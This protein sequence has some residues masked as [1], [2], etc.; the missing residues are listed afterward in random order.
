M[1]KVSGLAGMAASADETYRP[2][3]FELADRARSSSVTVTGVVAK[4]APR[5]GPK[6]CIPVLCCFCVQD[7]PNNPCPCKG[8]VIWLPEPFVK[9]GRVTGRMTSAFGE[10]QVLLAFDLPSDTLIFADDT[11]RCRAEDQDGPTAYRRDRDGELVP[12][13][14]EIWIPSFMPMTVG[15][16]SETVEIISSDESLTPIA[17]KWSWSVVGKAVSAF[18]FGWKVGRAIADKFGTD[19]KIS[20]W[21]KEHFPRD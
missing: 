2:D 5:F 20:G 11:I 1:A 10:G 17:L 12:V 13:E 16:L 14:D 8:P 7:T 4:S 3:Y 9:H 15:E 18:R 19:K 21:L 6:G